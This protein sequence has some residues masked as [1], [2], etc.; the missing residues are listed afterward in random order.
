MKK[1]ITLCFFA[2]TLC[3]GIQTTNA[4]DLIKINTIANEKA[5]E[6]R[7]FLKFDDETLEEVYQAYKAY[8][9]KDYSI[10]Q[11]TK[12]NPQYAKE[13][14]AKNKE[15]LESKF[16]LLFTEDQFE[17]YNKIDKAK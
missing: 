2:L 4:Q 5:N 7:K 16:K 11:S 10:E 8:E 14:K 9:A 13:A 1:I 15:A 3:F 17:L 12:D 6:L